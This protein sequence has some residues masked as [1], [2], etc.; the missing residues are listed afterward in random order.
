MFSLTANIGK[1]LLEALLDQWPKCHLVD[2]QGEIWDKQ[3]ISSVS[4]I[5]LI[6]WL[7]S[8]MNLVPGKTCVLV[9]KT[10][11]GGGG[12]G[13]GLKLLKYLQF[14]MTILSYLK[15]VKK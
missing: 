12:G 6:E 8:K 9:S 2:P 15:L 4:E 10:L 5:F 11:G 1:T 14:F 13:L 7:E 3:M